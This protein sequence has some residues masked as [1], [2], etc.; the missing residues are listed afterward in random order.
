MTHIGSSAFRA[1]LDLEDVT[2]SANITEIG[3]LLFYECISLSSITIPEKVT[4]IGMSAFQ[5]TSISSITIPA[6]V[7]H[8]SVFV[9]LDCPIKKVYFNETNGWMAF[10]LVTQME[11]NQISSNALSNPF[12]AANL[13]KGEFNNFY[14]QRVSE[15]E[16]EPT[17]EQTPPPEPR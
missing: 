8:I 7:T 3:E 11:G 14:W 15:P 9:F 4:S 10:L 17:P 5:G 1:C 2:L 12:S 13:L 16:P 6:A